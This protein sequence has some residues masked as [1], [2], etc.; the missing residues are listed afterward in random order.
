MSGGMKLADSKYHL[1]WGTVAAALLFVFGLYLP[2]ARRL[3]HLW[4][5]IEARQAEVDA[6][7]AHLQGML[8]LYQG[9]SRGQAELASFDQA[10][11]EG[12]QLG[13]FLETLDRLA[14]EAGL[15]DKNVVPS[16]VID[17]GQVHC[18]PLEIDF[19]GEF[20]AVYEFL[21]RVES[22]PRITRV[23]R[24]RLSSAEEGG[25]ELL[26][27]LTVQVYFRNS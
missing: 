6:R 15:G 24:L 18:L 2:E 27:S 17:S 8:A 22:L 5:A 14:A 26:S 25:T 11:P 16:R 4:A 23:Q 9:V 21:R 12:K 3:D 13:R 19:N 7:G 10:V 1:V 20:E